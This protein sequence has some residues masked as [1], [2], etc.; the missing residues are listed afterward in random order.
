MSMYIEKVKQLENN[1]ENLID[2]W[3]DEQDPR[4]PD[5]NT[6]VPREE[7]QQRQIAIEEAKI[8]RR[9][10]V[11]FREFVKAIEKDKLFI[12]IHFILK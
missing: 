5:K 9:L 4:I 7:I 8:A 1:I 10:L 6:W 3:K 2:E 12:N 11:T